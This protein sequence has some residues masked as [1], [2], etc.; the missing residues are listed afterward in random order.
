MIDGPGI[1]LP[2]LATLLK[3][4]RSLRRGHALKRAGASSMNLVQEGIVGKPFL[5]SFERQLDRNPPGRLAQL[6]DRLYNTDRGIKT[7]RD[8]RRLLLLLVAE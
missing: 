1:A 6:F 8:P 3:K 7:G 4:L 5:S 2:L